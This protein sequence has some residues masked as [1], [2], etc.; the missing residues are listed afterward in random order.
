V[1]GLA[2]AETARIL[3]VPVGT[4]RSRLNRGRRLLGARLGARGHVGRAASVP[5]VERCIV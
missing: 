5:Q 4:V 1:Q 2:Y 3:H